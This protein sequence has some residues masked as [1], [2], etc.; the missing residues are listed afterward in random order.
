MMTF[1]ASLYKL[2]NSSLSEFS[3]AIRYEGRLLKDFSSP[4][5]VLYKVPFPHLY[6]LQARKSLREEVFYGRISFRVVGLFP[7]RQILPQ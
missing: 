7:C 2:T 4:L 3:L 1:T 5:L 6:S